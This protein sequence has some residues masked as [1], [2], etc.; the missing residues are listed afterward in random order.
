MGITIIMNAA[1]P[2]Y[3]FGAFEDFPSLE[4]FTAH[5][6]DEET[7]ARALFQ[8]KWPRGFR[9]PRCSYSRYTIVNRRRLPLFE[10]GSCH[11]QASITVGTIMEKSRTPLVQWF[12]AMYLHTR[13]EGISALRLMTIIGTTYKTAWL[14]CHK[15][16]D[17]I[18]QSDADVRLTGNVH[19]NCAQYGT[20]YNPTAYRH[21]QEHPLL[22]GA[23]VDP[24][25]TISYLKIKQVATDDLWEDMVTPSGRETFIQEHVDASRATITAVIKKYSFQRNRQLLALGRQA[26]WWIDSVFCGIGAKHLQAYLDQYCFL[27]NLANNRK[28]NFISLLERCA[29]TPVLTYANLIN[30]PDKTPRTQTLVALYP[31]LVRRTSRRAG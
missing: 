24:N 3:D 23:S 14:I 29:T 7:C 16:R 13:N 22:V 21:P 6:Q 25:G 30:K 11:H 5:Y 26:S 8:A 15:I 4:Q 10:C 19:I 17:A 2:D 9:C 18:T 27:Y 20:P 31:K 28:S 1:S 12:K